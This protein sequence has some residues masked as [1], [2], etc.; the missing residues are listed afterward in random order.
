MYL[1]DKMSI[2]SIAKQLGT[3]NGKISKIL[4]EAGVSLRTKSQA[5]IERA[6]K[7]S[8]FHMN[9]SFFDD[10][11]ADM[12]WVLGLMY[13]DGHIGKDF[14]RA[15]LTAKDTNF[16]G[17]VRDLMGSN[18]RIEIRAST[19]QLIINGQTRVFKLMKYGLEPSKSL[20]CLFPDVPSEYLSHFVR[21]VWD[22][23]GCISI[24]KEGWLTVGLEM[25]SESFILSTREVLVDVIDQ[26]VYYSKRMRPTRQYEGRSWGNT[27]PVHSVRLHGQNALMVCRWMYKNSTPENRW[28]YKFDK[29]AGRI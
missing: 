17:Q 4:Y 23:D 3:Y 5:Q 28:A 1:K 13:T 16:L 6:T 26:E 8:M 7:E 14:S 22:G 29:V 2:G 27:N 12:A 18:F 9:E 24:R 19:P 15:G 25:G 21:G 11:S 10:W 20:T